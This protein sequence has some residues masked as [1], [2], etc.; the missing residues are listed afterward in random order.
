[1]NIM[2]KRATNTGAKHPSSRPLQLESL[3]VRQFR[4]RLPTHT[5]T[6]LS[7][8]SLLQ[9]LRFRCLYIFFHS[10][11]EGFLAGIINKN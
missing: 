2:I 7:S 11:A 6:C 10:S 3:S 8:L 4:P 1:M 9:V 5:L